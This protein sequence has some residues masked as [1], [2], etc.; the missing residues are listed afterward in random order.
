MVIIG[1]LF[2]ACKLQ[3]ENAT[4][5]ISIITDNVNIFFIQL[6]GCKKRRKGKQK[7]RDVQSRPL[8]LLPNLQVDLQIIQVVIFL[9]K[10]GLK[11]GLSEAENGA[12]MKK[13]RLAG[14]NAKMRGV[15]YI[16]D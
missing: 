13:G 6:S 16:A 11:T 2:S 15:R 9:Y 7:K 12:E 14:K 10:Q 8:F 3:V 1:R 5:T 4:N